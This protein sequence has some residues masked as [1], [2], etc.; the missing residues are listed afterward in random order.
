MKAHP[1]KDQVLVLGNTN[2]HRSLRRSRDYRNRNGLWGWRTTIQG[3]KLSQWGKEKVKMKATRLQSNTL[4]LGRVTAAIFTCTGI[5][6]FC[7][8]FF[9]HMTKAERVTGWR[10]TKNRTKD[11][12][13]TSQMASWRTAGRTQSLKVR[14]NRLMNSFIMHNAAIF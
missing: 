5:P 6:A 14:T 12:S 11:R 8:S 10:R 1:V 3:A 4:S 13:E 9:L 2:H 7:T